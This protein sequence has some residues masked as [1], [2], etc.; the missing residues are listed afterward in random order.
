MEVKE[1]IT[2]LDEMNFSLSVKEGKLILKGDKIKLSAAETEAIKSNTEVIDY[3]KGHKNELIDYLTLFPELSGKKNK[4]IVAVYKLSSLQQGMLFHGLYDN[5][6]SYIEQFGFDLV[7]V[8]PNVLLASWDEIIK[9]HS[10]LRSAFYY[11]SFLCP[12]I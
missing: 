4:D 7:N 8:N 5:S 10:I 1:F 9:N 11:N 2:K 12:L 6:G 3:I